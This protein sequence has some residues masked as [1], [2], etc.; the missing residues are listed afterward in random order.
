VKTHFLKLFS[1]LN[2][3]GSEE[4]CKADKSEE[5]SE[6]ILASDVEI[7]INLCAYAVARERKKKKRKNPHLMLSKE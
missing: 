3:R 2:V 6:I 4:T 1:F 7:Y 5:K